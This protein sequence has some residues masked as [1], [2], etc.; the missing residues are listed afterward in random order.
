[1]RLVGFIF[2]SGLLSSTCGAQTTPAIP[3]D[4]RFVGSLDPVF[5]SYLQEGAADDCAYRV[6]QAPFSFNFMITR[7]VGGD[8]ALNA[9][10][11]IGDPAGLANN[12]VVSRY[13][14]LK[15]TYSDGLGDADINEGGLPPGNSPIDDQVSVNGHILSQHLKSSFGQPFT[16]LVKF[17]I[18]YLKFPHRTPG[19]ISTEVQNGVLNVVTIIPNLS[20]F[21]MDLGHIHC[22]SEERNPGPIGPQTIEF[23]AMAPVLLVHGI[24]VPPPP[25]WFGN[26]TFSPLG[27]SAYSNGWFEQ[28]FK[29]AKAPFKSLVFQENLIYV[30]AQN[31]VQP[32]SQAAAEF[33]AQHIHIVAHSMG[34]LWSRAFLTT[35]LPTLPKKLGVFSVTT[36]DTPHHGSYNAA[37][38]TLLDDAGWFSTIHLTPEQ[39][40]LKVF[41]PKSLGM[42][43]LTPE[44]VENFNRNGRELPVVTVV[45]LTLVTG[46]SQMFTRQQKNKV[47][48]YSISADANIDNSCEGLAS[49]PCDKNHLPTITPFVASFGN[50]GL[51]DESEGYESP[52]P[53]AGSIATGLNASQ[54][55]YRNLYQYRTAVLQPVPGLSFVRQIVSKPTDPQLNDFQVT[56]TSARYTGFTEIGAS[57]LKH[58]HTTVGKKDVGVIV[59]SYIQ[60]L[61]SILQSQNFQ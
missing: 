38:R 3:T 30:G 39:A 56:V 2:L 58:N 45:P 37:L 21:S 7:V 57:P 35:F 41:A 1:M 47:F 6:T 9:D 48:Y 11:T 20:V 23:F 49:G 59:L 50:P 13:A 14:T 61:S 28:P 51:P 16:N 33:G 36:I 54:Y 46:D 52:D 29:D 17:P 31:L 12:G 25:D 15:I 34:G 18:E 44:A 32:I 22:G 24:R 27:S 40:V 55:L 53:D 8:G 19:A 60:I 42:P 43:E 4:T 26:Y 10:G 5:L